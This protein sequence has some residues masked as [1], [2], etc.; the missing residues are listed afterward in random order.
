MPPPPLSQF[1]MLFRQADDGA[2]L[3]TCTYAM[4]RWVTMD[5]GYT[6][7]SQRTAEEL[8]AKAVELRQMAATATTHDVMLALESLAARYKALA[9]SRHVDRASSR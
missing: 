8:L 9:E 1:Q 7:L 4:T 5:S 3:R 2:T 6:P